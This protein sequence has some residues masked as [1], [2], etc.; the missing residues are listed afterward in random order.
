LTV[1]A[2]LEQPD[3]M[4]FTRAQGEAALKYVVLTVMNQPVDGPMARSLAEAMIENVEDFLSL[5]ETDIEKLSF[6][7]T[8]GEDPIAIGP[9][10]RGILRAFIA[11]IRYRAAQDNPIRDKW[12]EI[13]QEEFDTYRVGP[14]FNGTIF[15]SP[16]VNNPGIPAASS[17]HARDAVA[18]FKR[19]IKRDPLQFP[20]LKDDKQW[21]GWN[22]SHN[23]QA[24]AQ[25]VEDVMNSTYKPTTTEDKALFAV[26][27]TY[28]FAVFEKTL[29]TDQGKAYVREFEK[30]SDAQSIYRR[31]SEYAIK[32]TKA[33]LE[34]STI[35]SYITSCKLGEGSAW[36]GP[37]ASFVLHW[38]NQVRLYEA[39][40]EKEEYFSNGQKRHMLQNAVHPVQ[41]L[42]AVKTQADQHKTQTEKELTYDQ[43]VNLLLSAASAYDAQFAPK[44]HFA[45]RAPRRA[46]YSHDFTASNEDNDPGYDIDSALGIVQPKSTHFAA[47]TPRHVVYSHDI[48]ES[49]DDNDPAYDIDCA[50][51]IIQAN[52]RPPGTSSMAL[53]QWTQFLSQDA[54]D[55]WDKLPD[56]AKD[57]LELESLKMSD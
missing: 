34:A 19:G 50:L 14:S 29:L 33:S 45:A 22:R 11:F 30:E 40:V 2:L 41:E 9:G 12:N 20:I 53:S 10:Q 26:K 7:A 28:M 43:Y 56:E 32:S 57:I 5:I 18:D 8:P 25:G 13:T 42:R 54:I 39:Q 15:G 55:I 16:S 3:K 4:P 47:R 27:Q 44:T 17:T 23:A 48:K 21:D 6:I 31:I 46:V 49:N 24:R 52:G 1:E 35:L 37:T 38:Q 36:R 51:D